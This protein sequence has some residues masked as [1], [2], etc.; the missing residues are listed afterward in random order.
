MKVCP[1]CET[2]FEFK[3]K[4]KAK[5]TTRAKQ[6][7]FKPK[8]SPVDMMSAVSNV[9]PAAKRV[10]FNPPESLSD[11]KREKFMIYKTQISNYTMLINN[12]VMKMEHLVLSSL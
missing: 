4:A 5:K 12:I 3:T 7:V 10:V 2:P 6:T 11:K 9:P 8:A 1:D